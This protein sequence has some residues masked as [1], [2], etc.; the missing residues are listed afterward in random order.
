MSVIPLN[1]EQVYRR[2]RVLTWTL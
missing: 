2:I 1:V